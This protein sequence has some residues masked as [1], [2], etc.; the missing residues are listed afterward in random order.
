[1][2]FPNA[3]KGVRRI[4]IAELLMLLAAGLMIVT[5]IFG[6]INGVKLGTGEAQ[7]AENAS[8][9]AAFTALAVAS[10]LLLLVAFIMNLAGVINASKDDQ[11]FKNALWTTLIGI[12]LSL[13]TSVF[14]GTFATGSAASNWMNLISSIVSLATTFF[15]LSGIISLAQKLGDASTRG[16][17]EK[18]QKMLLITYAVSMVLELLVILLKNP[19]LMIIVTILVY[20]VDMITYIIY[21]R[22]LVKAKSMLA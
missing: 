18:A 9:P 5:L 6:A 13:A 2:K 4:Y 8:V 7:I 16:T 14:P 22:A 21:L 11:G 3:A 17:A 10:T 12:G 15:I 19:T 20:V 1:M